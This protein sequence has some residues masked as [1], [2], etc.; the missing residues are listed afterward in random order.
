MADGREDGQA[1]GHG[2]A[3]AAP[4]RPVPADLRVRGKT[5]EVRAQMRAVG[6]SWDGNAW[7]A[8]TAAVWRQAQDIVNGQVLAPPPADLRAASTQDLVLELI[9]REG[10]VEHIGTVRL[11]AELRKR[12]FRVG[13]DLTDS[14]GDLLA[15]APEVD[16][17]AAQLER[18]VELYSVDSSAFEEPADWLTLREIDQSKGKP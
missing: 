15:S 16:E 11:V 1:P 14:I 13:E 6:C 3:P 18:L 4:P 5:Y 7:V 8:P 2:A 10:W 9:M 17:L 12:G